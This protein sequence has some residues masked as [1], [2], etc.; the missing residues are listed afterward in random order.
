MRT[1]CWAPVVQT[2]GVVSTADTAPAL[3]SL[4]P[5][6]ATHVHTPHPG[7]GDPEQRRALRLVVVTPGCAPAGLAPDMVPAIPRGQGRLCCGRSW[8]PSW[9][10]CYATVPA[11]AA[12]YESQGQLG[13]LP[14]APTD[15]PGRSVWGWASVSL[16]GQGPLG[17]P[18]PLKEPVR[19]PLFGAG[20]GWHF[21]CLSDFLHVFLAGLPH[22]V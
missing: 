7:A 21:E 14:G 2:G 10:S 17:T 20:V 3:G 6:R 13:K 15:Q 8:R 22:V 4:L 12:H 19:R 1:V 5:A 16:R 11:M 18:S 9:L